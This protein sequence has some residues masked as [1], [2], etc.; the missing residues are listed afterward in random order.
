[1]QFVC[2]SRLTGLKRSICS[3][4]FDSTVLLLIHSFTDGL[5]LFDINYSFFSVII[6]DSICSNT[7]S[8]CVESEGVSFGSSN[9]NDIRNTEHFIYGKLF[10][11][12][13]QKQSGI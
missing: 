12:K 6:K 13:K 4:A 8:S 11:Y 10:F 7:Y 5:K 1:M 2:V 3:L 9:A